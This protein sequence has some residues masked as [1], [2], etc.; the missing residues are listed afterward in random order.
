MRNK[1]LLLVLLLWEAFRGAGLFFTI[2]TFLNPTFRFETTLMLAWLFTGSLTIL[3]TELMLLFRGFSASDSSALAYL[4]ALGKTI[5]IIPGLVLFFLL[6]GKVPLPAQ[7]P[8]L[9][10]QLR[11]II[12]ILLF[13]DL[14][15]LGILLLLQKQSNNAP[16]EE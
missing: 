8:F 16:E 3:A 7:G 4:A 6:S 5:S 11:P 2:V 15:C 14:I 12:G 1:L 9:L 13:L 10:L